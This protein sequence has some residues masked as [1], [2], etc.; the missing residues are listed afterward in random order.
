MKRYIALLSIVT[1]IFAL[2]G[3]SLI[4]DDKSINEVKERANNAIMDKSEDD[5]TQTFQDGDEPNNPTFNKDYVQPQYTESINL[6]DINYGIVVDGRTFTTKEALR[7]YLNETET[8][9][10][11][12]YNNAPDEF[13]KLSQYYINISKI[14]WITEYSSDYKYGAVIFLGDDK[15]FVKETP[16]QIMDMINNQ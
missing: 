12:T 10:Q 9:I 7:R 11:T 13:I 16:E 8:D 6:D 4:N 15:V 3:C 14:Q 2:S 5:G 1:I